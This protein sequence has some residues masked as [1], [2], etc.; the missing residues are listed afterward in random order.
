MTCRIMGEYQVIMRYIIIKQLESYPI[1]INVIGH[2]DQMKAFNHMIEP[3]A[4]DTN[5]VPSTSYHDG[6]EVRKFEWKK[7][8]RWQKIR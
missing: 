2:L 7:S 1:S 3:K 4:A 6:S 5:Q 8:K